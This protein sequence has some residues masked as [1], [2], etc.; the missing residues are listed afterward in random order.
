MLKVIRKRHFFQNFI[1]GVAHIL[2]QES[3][4]KRGRRRSIQ[5]VGQ[6]FL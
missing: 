5:N 4:G 2:S 1:F 3:R 6:N